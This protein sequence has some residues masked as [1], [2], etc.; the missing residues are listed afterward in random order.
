MLFKI[1]LQ[2]LQYW[3]HTCQNFVRHLMGHSV[4]S[5]RST[6]FDHIIRKL[7]ISV[8]I[9]P[10]QHHWDEDIIGFV[11]NCFPSYRTCDPNRY[12]LLP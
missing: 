12:R 9:T 7:T 6:I 4:N 10:V 3:L 11:P 1:L 5:C 2:P 8:H